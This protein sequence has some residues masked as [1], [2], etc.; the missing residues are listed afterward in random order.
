MEQSEHSFT[1][2]YC[3]QT[4]SM[5]LDPSAGTQSYVEDCENCCHPI[6]ITY[7]TENDEVVSVD[8]TRAQ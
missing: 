5:V 4:I 1:C 6:L 3:W 2:P 8:A 7:T